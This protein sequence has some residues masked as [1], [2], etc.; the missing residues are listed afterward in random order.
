[1]SIEILLIRLQLRYF[2]TGSKPYK[3]LIGLSR[4]QKNLNAKF[5]R[6][7]IDGAEW[8]ENFLKKN[9]NTSLLRCLKA[10]SPSHGMKSTHYLDFRAVL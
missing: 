5:V 2:S 10:A 4:G 8:K 9:S 6:I 1:M 3:Q 7:N